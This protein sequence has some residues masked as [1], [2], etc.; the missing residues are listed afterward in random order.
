MYSQ[1][2]STS[3]MPEPLELPTTA[4]ASSS[5]SCKTRTSP[6]RMIEAA[7][8]KTDMEWVKEFV[9]SYKADKKK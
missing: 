9:N 8:K 3:S 7:K 6:L 5:N 4:Q 1:A 2:A